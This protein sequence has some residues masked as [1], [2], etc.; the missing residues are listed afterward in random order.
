M[1]VQHTMGWRAAPACLAAGLLCGA[2]TGC[3]SFKSQHEI[4]PIH[5]TLDVNLKVEK[6]LANFFDDIDEHTPQP[7]TPTKGSTAGVGNAAAE[8]GDTK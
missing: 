6:E 1:D 4:K 2:M 3:F 7:A 5:I 8:K